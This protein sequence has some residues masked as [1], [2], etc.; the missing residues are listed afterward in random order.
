MMSA[1]L[2]RVADF[3][4]VEYSSGLEYSSGFGSSISKKFWIQILKTVKSYLVFKK[5][6]R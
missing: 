1:M 3:V 6:V 4:F 2:F 5:V